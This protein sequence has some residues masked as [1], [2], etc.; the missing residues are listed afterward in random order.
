[1][2]TPRIPDGLS[3]LRSSGP[4]RAWLDSLPGLFERAVRRWSLRTGDPFPH[5]YASL[6]VPATLPDGTEAVLKLAFPH[7]ESE[8]EAEALR[9]WAGRGAVRLLDDDPDDG[10]LLIERCRPGTPL[11]DLSPRDG[12]DVVVGLLP[13]TWVPGGGPFRTLAA[14]AEWWAGYLER[15]W[16]ETG[17]GFPRALLGAALEALGSLPG[18]QGHLVLVNQDLHAG[19][20]LSAEREPWLV[21]DPK[22]LLGEREFGVAPVVRDRAL[23]HGRREVLGRLER[24]CADLQLDRTRARAWALAQTV[25]WSF[26]GNGVLPGHVEVATWLSA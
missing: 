10:A 15:R 11:S 1:M 2:T 9:T 3:P 23:G 5:A 12:L 16:E 19:N 21:I 13:R 6:A 14:E 22:P 18:T 8:H 24:L 17:R 26:E 4:G 20:I 25:A 7:R